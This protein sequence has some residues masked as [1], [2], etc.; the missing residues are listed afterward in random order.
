MSKPLESL[1]KNKHKIL[2]HIITGIGSL[3]LL[4]ICQT[5]DNSVVTFNVAFLFG[6]FGYDK[7]QGYLE[8]RLGE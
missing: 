2:S 1:K 8:K 7:A 5:I 6:Y 4:G 3:V